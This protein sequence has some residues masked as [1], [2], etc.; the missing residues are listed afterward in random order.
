MPDYA[1]APVGISSLVQDSI[2]VLRSQLC[3]STC[4]IWVE[5]DA[6]RRSLLGCEILGPCGRDSS[7]LMPIVDRAHYISSTLQ[8]T[9]DTGSGPYYEAICDW[10]PQMWGRARAVH[11]EGPRRKFEQWPCERTQ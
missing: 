4:M 10:L 8:P 3:L 11:T 2:E 1:P 5:R 9:F 7:H 6:I